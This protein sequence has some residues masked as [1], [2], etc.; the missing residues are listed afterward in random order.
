MIEKK[1]AA[2]CF[3]VRTKINLHFSVYSGSAV[4]NLKIINNTGKKVFESSF[5]MAEVTSNLT[6]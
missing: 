2:K 6:Y 5:E 1:M 4:S 3:S